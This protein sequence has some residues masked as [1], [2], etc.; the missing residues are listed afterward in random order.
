MASRPRSS[1]EALRI[2][3]EVGG[4]AMFFGALLL[5]LS[6]WSYSPWEVSFYKNPP[7]M[8]SNWIG[9]VGLYVAWTSFFAV[10]VIAYLLPLLAAI[11]AGLA[12][13]GRSFSFRWSLLL[14]FIMVITAAGL[15][16]LPHFFWGDSFLHNWRDQVKVDRAGGIIG[17]QLNSLLLVR[18][19]GKVGALIVLSSIYSSALVLLLRINPLTIARQSGPWLTE[20]IYQ[21]RYRRADM[22]E[23]VKMELLKKEKEIEKQLCRQR[24]LA[25]KKENGNGPILPPEPAT[26]PRIIDTTRPSAEPSTD[27]DEEDAPRK[28]AKRKTPKT[29][30][31][32]RETPDYSNYEAPPLDMLRR[33]SGPVEDALTEDHL[34][35]NQNQII[36]AFRNFDIMTTAG[37]ILKGPT[38]VRYE[39]YPDARVRVERIQGLERNIA[40]VMKAEKVNILAPVPGKETVAVELPRADKIPIVLRDQLESPLFQ[41]AKARIPLA[42]GQDIYGNT[43]IA[44]L[45]DMPHL[46][47]AGTTGSGKS[48]C[49]NCIILSLLY[50][51]SPDELRI[52]LVDPKVVE[53]QGYNGLPHLAVPVVTDAKKVLRALRWAI[54]EMEKR[55]TIMARAKVRNIASYNARPKDKPKVEQLDLDASL[56]TPDAEEEPN[57][58]EPLQQ[59][60][61]PLEKE[62][63]LPD[64]MPYIVVIID[65]LADLMQTAPKDVEAAIS[66]LAAKARAAG[67][68][69]ILATQ[70]PRADVVTG[71]IKANIPCRIA[72]QVNSSLDSRVILDDRGAENL[73]GKGDLL[74][75]PPGASKKVRAQGAFVGD[76]E[77][78]AVVANLKERYPESYDLEMNEELSQS[79][80]EDDEDEEGLS[81]EDE[82]I[83][84][85]ARDLC[86]KLK[87][88]GKRA[89][90]SMFQRKLGLGYGRA[91]RIMDVLEDRGIVGPDNGAKGRDILID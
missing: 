42:I 58:E 29:K 3:H 54:N 34:R 70:T 10:G 74:Y 21:W 28:P 68:H 46:L 48:V 56:K 66:R 55:Y 64:R 82:E 60:V 5:L 84:E 38:I 4:I 6:L 18:S 17:E 24:K 25:G 23:R 49:V 14:C 11:L 16:D 32:E 20:Q 83:L 59:P 85:N 53:M 33:V 7:K 8:C 50:R 71:V 88:Q 86:L 36:E 89:S 91:A 43:L 30:A 65:E 9:P 78:N 90:T 51:F 12:L 77:V 45:A 19:L 81:N 47:I 22:K 2:R 61:L 67:I 41:S 15:A 87:S 72:F 1:P 40:R 80:D 75:V 73:L 52:I 39:L 57:E 37:E 63:P 69:L 13:W 44:D 62:E 76:D 27:E 26:P 31:Q 35:S 79:F